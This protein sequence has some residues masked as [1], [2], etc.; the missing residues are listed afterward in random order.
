MANG[1]MCNEHRSCGAFGAEPYSIF[2]PR[3][4]LIFREFSKA[5]NQTRKTNIFLKFL[6]KPNFITYKTVLVTGHKIAFAPF[7]V[8]L[9]QW[10]AGAHSAR[11]GGQSVKMA[12]PH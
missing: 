4:T 9:E 7:L 6:P 5:L 11:G 10:R 1:V 3:S 2:R 12:P 8:I